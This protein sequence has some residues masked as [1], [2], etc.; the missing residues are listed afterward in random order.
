MWNKHLVHHRGVCHG[1]AV[2]SCPS[3]PSRSC[4]SEART[5]AAGPGE[6]PAG[7]P[8]PGPGLPA[9]SSGQWPRW[10]RRGENPPSADSLHLVVNVQLVVLPGLQGLV[11]VQVTLDRVVLQDIAPV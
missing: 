7:P 2:L 8:S 6:D 11:Q 10:A 5:D 9:S 3:S 1:R 4:L